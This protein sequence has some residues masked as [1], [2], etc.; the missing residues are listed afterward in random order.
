MPV[1]YKKWIIRVEEFNDRKSGR[2]TI[3]IAKPDVVVI[4]PFITENTILLE[5]HYRPV[6]GK[7]ILELP[8]GHIDKGERPIQSARRELLEETGY[9]AGKMKPA[10]TS[11]DAPGLLSSRMYF[12]IATNMR[13]VGEKT[14]KHE[15]QRP[16][17]MKVSKALDMVKR[18]KIEDNK[19]ISALLFYEKFA[20]RR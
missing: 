15:I 4:L 6:I 12:F 3:R 14:D 7:N 9:I 16:L 1:V 13:R 10:F 11:F 20:S 5:K 2:F 19:T 17:K 18:G 8:A